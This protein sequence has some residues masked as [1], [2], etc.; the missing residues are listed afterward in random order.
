MNF[1]KELWEYQERL[2]VLDDDI[3][4]PMINCLCGRICYAT[5]NKCKTCNIDLHK[6]MMDHPNKILK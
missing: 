5:D 6:L 1:N 2:K 3:T 4:N